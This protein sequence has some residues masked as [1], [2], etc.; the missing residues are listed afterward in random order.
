M[1]EKQLDDLMAMFAAVVV[2]QGQIIRELDAEGL[3]SKQRLTEKFE[4][5]SAASSKPQLR[6]MLGQLVEALKADEATALRAM[7]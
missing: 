3:L 7:H 2:I 1:T 6:A 4:A 5:L